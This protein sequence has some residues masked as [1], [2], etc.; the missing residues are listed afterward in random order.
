MVAEST[1]YL[2]KLVIY[3]SQFGALIS[4]NNNIGTM[5]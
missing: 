2:I 1:S 4:V 3:A 5:L